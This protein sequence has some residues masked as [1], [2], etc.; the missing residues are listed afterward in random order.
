MGW[1]CFIA[2]THVHMSIYYNQFLLAC[3][4]SVADILLDYST[5]ELLL[6]CEKLKKC[7]LKIDD[8]SRTLQI[9]LGCGIHMYRLCKSVLHHS[10]HSYPT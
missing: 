1:W 9:P 4:C 7:L 6:H 5:D 8:I 10:W 2:G 3:L